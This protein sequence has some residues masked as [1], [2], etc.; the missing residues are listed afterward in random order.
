MPDKSC[1]K[2]GVPAYLSFLKEGIPALYFSSEAQ[3]ETQE[4]FNAVLASEI[5]HELH[6][7]TDVDRPL[8]VINFQ[9]FVG[10]KRIKQFL[11]SPQATKYK[12]VAFA[13]H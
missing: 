10:L 11:S 3:E 7:A 9:R 4:A 6:A 1:V 12:K 13:S 2:G 5:K 8:L